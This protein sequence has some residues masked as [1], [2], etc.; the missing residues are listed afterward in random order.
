MS[1]FSIDGN[2]NIVPPDGHTSYGWN[3]MK[4]VGGVL[5]ARFYD[6]YTTVDPDTGYQV[7]SIDWDAG[8]ATQIAVDWYIDRHV[9]TDGTNWYVFLSNTGYMGSNSYTATNYAFYTTDVLQTG[10]YNIFSRKLL[11]SDVTKADNQTMKITYDIFI[12]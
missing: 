7:A 9:F 1:T 2:K 6:A 10:D 12:T 11:P 4:I 5:T 3:Y 8:T